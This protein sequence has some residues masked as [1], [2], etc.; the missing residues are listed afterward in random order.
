M[1]DRLLNRD[2]ITNRI[3]GA[4]AAHAK[5]EPIGLVWKLFGYRAG[6][7]VLEA[8][9]AA[10]RQERVLKALRMSPRILT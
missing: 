5:D 8:V 6:P 7:H 2:F 3:I 9:L 1:R 10:C 4:S